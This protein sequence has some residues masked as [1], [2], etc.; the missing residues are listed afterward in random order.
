LSDFTIKR[1]FV[2]KTLLV[3]VKDTNLIDLNC[4]A[5]L[6]MFSDMISSLFQGTEGKK[7]EPVGVHSQQHDGH[8]SLHAAVD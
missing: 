6:D 7:G 5:W 8:V 1:Y 4:S 3:T 2:C